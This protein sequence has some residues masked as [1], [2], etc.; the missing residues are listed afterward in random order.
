MGTTF[1]DRLKA[2]SKLY[3]APALNL[4]EIRCGM[5]DINSFKRILLYIICTILALASTRINNNFI[6]KHSLGAPGQ[7][8][9]NTANSGLVRIDNHQVG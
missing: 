3:F 5:K 6:Q 4:K 8:D 2:H 7:T 1:L 9:K